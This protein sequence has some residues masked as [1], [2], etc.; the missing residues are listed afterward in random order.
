M[1]RGEVDGFAGGND[2]KSKMGNF[3]KNPN[4]C[5][6]AGWALNHEAEGGNFF[7]LG[8]KPLNFYICHFMDI[9][10]EENKAPKNYIIFW[11]TELIDIGYG[12]KQSM[13]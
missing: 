2:F 10:S 9:L 1:H 7:F 11:L 6:F 13:R 3:R 5:L 12:A 8:R 4:R